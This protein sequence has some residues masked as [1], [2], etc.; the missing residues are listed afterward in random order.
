MVEKFFYKG[1]H[2]GK[3]NFTFYKLANKESFKSC[4]FTVI[5]L[6]KFIEKNPY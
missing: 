1:H 4:S 5:F 2:K 3:P 6:S